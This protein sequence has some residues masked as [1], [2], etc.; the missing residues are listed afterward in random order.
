MS[1]LI[2]P[3]TTRIHA[4]FTQAAA[5]SDD[6]EQGLIDP[7]LKNQLRRLRD[8][9]HGK[10]L[11]LL[12]VPASSEVMPMLLAALPQGVLPSLLPD[13]LP[14][15]CSLVPDGYPCVSWNDGSPQRSLTSTAR[16]LR[17]IHHYPSSVFPQPVCL[18]VLGDPEVI[19]KSPVLLGELIGCADLTLLVNLAETPVSTSAGCFSDI[20][21]YAETVINWVLISRSA[22]SVDGSESTENFDQW[23]LNQ[24]NILLKSPRYD[25][26]LL[27]AAA[28]KLACLKSVFQYVIQRRQEQIKIWNFEAT[29]RKKRQDD[30]SK[31]QM[32]LIRDLEKI[33]DE[34]LKKI[35]SDF[36]Q[37]Y[38]YYKTALDQANFSQ[39]GIRTTSY[40]YPFNIEG[41]LLDQVDS[42]DLEKMKTRRHEP[43]FKNQ[44]WR[45][46]STKFGN[47]EYRLFISNGKLALLAKTV[48]NKLKKH[49]DKECNGFN[50]AINQLQQ[51]LQCYL[52]D[53]NLDADLQLPMIKSEVLTT[54]LGQ[55]ICID[56]DETFVQ[57]GYGQR[58]REGR[59]LMGGGFYMVIMMLTRVFREDINALL[60]LKGTSNITSYL[61]LFIMLFS[62]IIYFPYAGKKYAAD[63]EKS[64]ESALNKLRKKLRDTIQKTCKDVVEEN[65]KKEFSAHLDQ[66]K[67]RIKIESD[68]L[69]AS[70]TAKTPIEGHS[71]KYI[72]LKTKTL[73]Q[74]TAPTAALS[75]FNSETDH[76]ALKT[77]LQKLKL[78][79][80]KA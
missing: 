29:H 36:V 4:L 74:L 56:G 52:H 41:V 13:P 78:E 11:H 7:P 75:K 14:A 54:T 38:R 1:A 53:N 55:P 12:I 80:E 34:E 30:G 9:F 46:L 22:E 49:V 45:Y 73:Q 31:N 27:I 51:T 20:P 8:D 44:L 62:L 69:R 23:F 35:R 66:V 59:M 15:L 70:M 10:N 77:D 32:D 48:Q 26:Y 25:G 40:C 24:L 21:G 39:S 6:V 47:T 60:N 33:A 28:R 57:Y 50:Q 61:M 16:Q 79:L 68:R 72:A 64:I 2:V 18:H 17:W 58:F 43:V 65:K 42:D 63:A 3:L 37:S 19:L 76:A 71:E 67:N 5:A